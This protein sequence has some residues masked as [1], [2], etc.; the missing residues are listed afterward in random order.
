VR[1]QLDMK[2]GAIA[3]IILDY[4]AV[5]FVVGVLVLD[6]WSGIRSGIVLDT[7]F[8]V[9]VALATAAW[10][11]GS[12]FQRHLARDISA[13]TDANPVYSPIKATPDKL[14]ENLR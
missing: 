13:R 1:P 9:V 8:V 3:A 12:R 7:M 2:L 14:T 10:L 4:A 6:R 5:A 11:A